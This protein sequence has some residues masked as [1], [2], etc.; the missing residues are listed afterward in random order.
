MAEPIVAQRAPFGVTIEAGRTYAWCACGRSKHQPFC[1]GSHKDTGFTPV[2]FKAEE[3]GEKWFCGC[4]HSAARPFCDG[5][6]ST[7]PATPV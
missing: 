3:S 1:D 5:T 6:H 2:V 4:K 7:L